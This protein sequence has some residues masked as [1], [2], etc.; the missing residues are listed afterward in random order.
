MP[1][2]D[3]LQFVSLLQ[4]KHPDLLTVVL[5]GHVT[6][7]HRALCLNRGAEL[8]LQKPQSAE[9]W[10]ILFNSL[11]EL[12][13]FKPQQGFRGV[14]R[15]VGLQD[16]LQMECLSRNS[17]VLEISTKEAR[18]HIYIFEGQIVHTEVG[19][20]TGEDAFNY[21]MSLSGGDFK[22]SP[23]IEPSQRSITGSWEFLLMEAARHRDETAPEEPSQLTGMP[24]AGDATAHT[25]FFK[26]A[27]EPSPKPA[28]RPEVA[29]FVILSSQGDLLYEW[30][31]ADVPGRISFLEFISKRARQLSQGLSLGNFEGF[32]IQGNR[33]RVVTQ[34][35]NDHAVLVRTN[36]AP[37]T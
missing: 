31:C 28:T 32:E 2:V 26:R 3:G 21:L 14:L 4:R 9:E 27:T 25:L 1:V 29:E 35:E 20:R 23:Y 8:Y 12:V 5:T 19:D 24:A 22:Q 30:Q 18:G 34:I 10:G 33:C 6:E 16:V 15:R 11:N 17:V 7:E 13:S 36:L 37:V